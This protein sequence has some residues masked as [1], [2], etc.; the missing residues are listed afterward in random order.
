[1][2]SH[3]KDDAGSRS[4]RLDRAS[5]A[6][7]MLSLGITWP[8]LQSLGSTPTFFTA[9]QAPPLDVAVTGIL[10]G[11]GVPGI[12]AF[13]A[14]RRGSAGQLAQFLS[15]GLGL[16]GLVG[17]ILESL[18]VV[19]DVVWLGV[20][21]C[22][23]VGGR[24]AFRS[25]PAVRQIFRYL[26]WS[27]ILFTL[28]FFATSAGELAWRSQR[29]NPPAVHVEDRPGTETGPLIVLIFDE[30]PTSAL[31]DPNGDIRASWFPGI[32]QVAKDGAWFPQ[33]W[34]SHTS[35]EF[36]LPTMLTGRQPD[37]TSPPVANEHPKNLFALLSARFRVFGH[38]SLTGFCVDPCSVL[39]APPAATVRW[40]T[41]MVD[42]SVVAARV[43][44][45]PSADDTFAIA[46]AQWANFG[47]LAANSRHTDPA[48][49]AKRLVDF[50]E[51][52]ERSDTAVIFH[53]LLPHRPWVFMPDG[54]HY[55]GESATSLGIDDQR[56]AVE[57][58]YYRHLAQVRFADALV[59]QIV[60]T[61]ERQ[62]TYQSSSILITA[63]HG[64]A[65]TPTGI[66]RSLTPENVWDNA[67]VPLVLKT[68][69][70]EPGTIDPYPAE[71]TDIFPTVLD[72]AGVEADSA[73]TGV[74]LLDTDRPDRDLVRTSSLGVP[75]DWSPA[76]TRMEALAERI[77][78]H[79]PSGDFWEFVPQDGPAVTVGSKAPELPDQWIISNA[80]R[81]KRAPQVPSAAPDAAKTGLLLSAQ[82]SGVLPRWVVVAVDDRV[83]AIAR[84]WESNEGP[85]FETFLSASRFESPSAQIDIFEWTGGSGG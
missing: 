42:L 62:G 25:S 82:S 21:A 78:T 81:I 29:Q 20:V 57:W 77:A 45:P 15:L 55:P 54:S 58:S 6:A 70:V 46:E 49:L 61:L 8:I 26:A 72:I 75:V 74:S 52:N 38:E 28:L 66:T 80:W 1:M 63:D 84:P 39:V 60:D 7:A 36:A 3:G 17:G 53:V 56:G 50:L 67:H 14:S 27:P 69:G 47:Q 35:T 13:L 44:L 48:V 83:A 68:P 10:V 31:L 65:F 30:L 9:R 5:S 23:V 43:L 18:G 2:S 33:S 64:I 12:A 4:H 22:S 34:S 37:G 32:A 76:D 16:V 85:F 41:L 24:M 19:N 11:L 73:V 71:T 51:T 40:S 79:F 59:S